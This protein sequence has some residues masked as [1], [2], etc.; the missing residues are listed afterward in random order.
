MSDPNVPIKGDAHTINTIY[1]A[2]ASNPTQAPEGNLLAAYL[3]PKNADYYTRHF[4]VFEE[5]NKTASWN[6]PAFFLTFPWLLYRKMWLNAALYVF[7]L[8]IMYFLMLFMFMAVFSVQTATALYYLIWFL[9][10]FIGVPI[11]AKSRNGAIK[12]AVIFG[13][14]GM[15]HLQ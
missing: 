4:R 5:E 14:G 2:P 9:T 3:G 11:F 12:W 13:Y 7:V 15:I 10:A 8:P 1:R 6:W